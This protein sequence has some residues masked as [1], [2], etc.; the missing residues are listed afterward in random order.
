MCSRD[1]AARLDLGSQGVSAGRG[2]GVM[3][4]RDLAAQLDLGSKGVPAGRG[5]GVTKWEHNCDYWYGTLLC[6]SPLKMGGGIMRAESVSLRHGCGAV[7]Q[8]RGCVLAWPGW[9]VGLRV[10]G[11]VLARSGC[12]A[13]R[14]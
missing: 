13:E 2:S 7:S 5:S 12:A 6:P 14:G 11:R 9:A 8:V 10:W 1:L 3:C 4:S